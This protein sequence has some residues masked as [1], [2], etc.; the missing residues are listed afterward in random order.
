MPDDFISGALAGQQFQLNKFLIQE[1]PI[2]L[3]QEKMALTIAK[4]DYSKRE[5]LASMLAAKPPPPG[6]DPLENATNTFFTMAQDA[7]QVGLP[8]EAATYLKEASTLSVQREDAAYKRWETTL[9]QTKFADQILAN[10][11]DQASLDQANAYI[12]MTTGKPSALEGQK[13]SPELVETLKKATMTKRSEAQ[14]A[15]DKARAEREKGLE[16]ADTALVEQRKAAAELSKVRA[17]IAKKHDADGLIAKP[18]TVTATVAELQDEYGASLDPATARTHAESIALD[19]ERIM[20]DEGKTLPQ[21]VKLAVRKARQD[22]P[23]AG[24]RPV[25]ARPGTSV[26]RPLPLPKDVT[27]PAQYQD[28]MIYEAPSGGWP[29]GSTE[30][31][32]WDAESQTLKKIE[33]DE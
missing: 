8:E 9:Q 21:A 29:D 23:L 26:K 27:D 22:G 32:F 20:S 25:K 30:P 33:E 2:K 18:R 1:A 28:Q 5:Q 16:K 13:Y 3:E 31:K 14:E 24:I 11:T 19:A 17:N 4:Q 12:K 6:Q 7:A 10:V 15:L